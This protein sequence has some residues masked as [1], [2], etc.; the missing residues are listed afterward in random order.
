M[1]KNWKKFSF[2]W[3]RICMLFQLTWLK[4]YQLTTYL[5]KWNV[6]FMRVPKS[7]CTSVLTIIH[8]NRLFRPCRRKLAKSVISASFHFTRA[9]N[10]SPSWTNC[11]REKGLSLNKRRN[12]ICSFFH[13]LCLIN[14]KKQTS[15]GQFK[16]NL[17]QTPMPLLFCKPL[18]WKVRPSYAEETLA[19]QHDPRVSSKIQSLL[20]LS[21][22]ANNFFLVVQTRTHKRKKKYIFY[23]FCALDHLQAQHNAQVSRV[24]SFEVPNSES[25]IWFG[26]SNTIKTCDAT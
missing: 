21:R 14:I 5:M 9:M 24:I 11:E 10:W 19:N 15:L 22:V 18:N 12:E 13:L 8:L 7:H 3:I 25:C 20:F 6:L 16:Y 1:E 2:I 23:L 17:K 4:K 26:S